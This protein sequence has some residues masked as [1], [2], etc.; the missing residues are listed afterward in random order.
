M[1]AVVVSP[2]TVVWESFPIHKCLRTVLLPDFGLETIVESLW[3]HCLAPR[4]SLARQ[5][6][7]GPIRVDESCPQSTPDV[8]APGTPCGAAR[9]GQSLSCPNDKG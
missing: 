6:V 9:L 2:Q 7:A 1:M 8:D 4:H 3:R 5:G